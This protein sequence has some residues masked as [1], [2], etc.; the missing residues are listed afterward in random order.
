MTTYRLTPDVSRVQGPLIVGDPS[1]R[2]R[3]RILLGQCAE[4]GPF[5]NLWLD[6]SGEQVAAVFGKRGT[7]KSYTLGVLLEGLAMGRGECAGA[8]MNSPRATLVLDIMDIYWTSR[9]P[10]AADGPPQIKKQYEVLSR[11]PLEAPPLAVDVWIPAGFARPEI[12]PSGIVELR[13]SPSSLALDDWAT[14]FDVDIFG[15]PRGMLIADAIAHTSEAGYLRG[16]GTHVAAKPDFGFAELLDCLNAD[17]DLVRNYQDM[18]LRSVRQRMSTYAS[19][20][21]FNGTGTAINA[22]LRPFRSSVLMLGRLPDAL[23]QVVVAT[24]LRQILRTRRDVSFA[25]KRLDIDASLSSGERAR[26]E[27]FVAHGLVR[28]WVLLDE[29]HVLA[30][31]Q[32]A[33]VA[34]A[35]LV[36]YAKE[37]RNYGL[38][39]AVA[40]QQPSALDPALLSQVET[41]ISHQL[42]APQDAAVAARGMR[43]PAPAEIV[44]DGTNADVETLLRRLGQGEALFSCGNA[45]SLARSCVVSIRPRVSAHGG[46]EA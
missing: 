34:S 18:T 11:R 45:P 6:I 14:L 23:K 5:R 12:D 17:A 29:A 25:Q 13:V 24:L 20:P 36:K 1:E 4:A 7:G 42:T 2:K 21:L 30:G 44:V 16:D 41:L 28:T 38:S 33:G 46:Y 39:L 19:L 35:A 26:L 40:T 27:G 43:S 32:Q 37:G 8:A 3:D 15:E 22:L 31:T 9:I 10:L